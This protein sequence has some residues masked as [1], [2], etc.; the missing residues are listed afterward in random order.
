ME[1][2]RSRRLILSFNE[3]TTHSQ[4]KFSLTSPKFPEARFI[5]RISVV[6][7]AIQTKDNEENHLITYCPNCIR[8]GRN[9]TNELGLNSTKSYKTYCNLR[10]ST[11]E[12][13]FFVLGY[14]NVVYY[15]RI[16]S[17]SQFEGAGQKAVQGHCSSQLNLKLEF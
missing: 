9:A 6:S 15:N 3:A 14:E 13:V 2:F 5:R 10:F 16:T 12:R 11:R 8:H 7:N 1:S 17:S 4:K